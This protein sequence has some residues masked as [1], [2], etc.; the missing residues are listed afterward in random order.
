MEGP[1]A[2]SGRR[3]LSQRPFLPYRLLPPRAVSPRLIFPYSALHLPLS[4]LTPRRIP[5]LSFLTPHRTFPLSFPVSRHIF[6]PGPLSPPRGGERFLRSF[7]QKATL[8]SPLLPIPAPV[9]SVSCIPAPVCS[10]SCIPPL[11]RSVS[12][13]STPPVCCVSCIPTLPC[14]AF[15]TSPP[16]A[17]PAIF[18]CPGLTDAVLCAILSTK[19]T[20]LQR[21]Q[22][23]TILSVNKTREK[24]GR[25]APFLFC[26]VWERGQNRPAKKEGA[27]CAEKGKKNGKKNM[28]PIACC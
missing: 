17:A 25:I 12:C 5:A 9:C 18:L 16:H 21:R 1:G 7:F 13:I 23:V 26:R 20:V 10:V 8:P 3:A 28:K 22:F 6:P 11:V 2:A 19:N 24:D 15:S 27:P 14:V 4:F